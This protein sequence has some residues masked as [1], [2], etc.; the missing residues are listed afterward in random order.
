[1][2]WNWEQI[3]TEYITTEKS[4]YRKLA[5]KYSIPRTTL[6]QRA[7]REGWSKLKRQ[8]RDNI[9]AKAVKSVESKKAD[10]LKRIQDITDRLLDTIEA[11]IDEGTAL[12][13]QGLKWL[14]GALKDIKDIQGIKSD[15]DMRE[16]EA[17]IAKLRKEAEAEDK[18]DNHIVVKI[19]DEAE[20]YSE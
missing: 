19:I 7:C 1:M 4:S 12:D 15:A 18:T 17:R 2:D 10:R 6:E 11:T 3:K 8:H 16:Q 14:T 9:V 20:E 13:K 5:E